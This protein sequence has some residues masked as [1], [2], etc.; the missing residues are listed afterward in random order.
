MGTPEFANSEIPTDNG[1]PFIEDTVTSSI[2][3]TKYNTTKMSSLLKFTFL[4]IA[5]KMKMNTMMKDVTT[6]GLTML[7]KNMLVKYAEKIRGYKYIIGG[8]CFDLL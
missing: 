8:F 2:L 6:P 7:G 5:Y 3:Y 1:Y 4:F